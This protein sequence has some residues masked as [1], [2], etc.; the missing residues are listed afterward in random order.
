MLFS[1]IIAL[2]KAGYTPADVREFLA[3][4]TPNTGA[5]EPEKP[6]TTPGEKTDIVDS[7]VEKVDNIEL[8]DPEKPTEAEAE[9]IDYKAQYEQTKEALAKA[10]AA[11]VRQE[12]PQ[13]KSSQDIINELFASIQQ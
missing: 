13:E 2:A 10:Q 9:A 5:P 1:D 8:T 12:L 4:E 11:N 7:S 6:E 3:V